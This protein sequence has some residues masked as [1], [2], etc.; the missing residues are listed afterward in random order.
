MSSV[1][2]TRPDPDALLQ[3]LKREEE[4]AKKGK[5]TIF[6]GMCA[7][8]G[9]TYDMLKTGQDLR[10]KGHDVII[11]YV[12]THHRQETEEL[13]T[14]LTILPRR[15]I[16]YNGIRLEEMDLDAIL[17][18]KPSLVLVDELAH[19]NIPGSRHAKRY[20]DVLE[21][22]D[23][24]ISVFTTLNVQHLESRAD[25][26]AQIAG[27][28]V[29][30]TVPD[31][32]FDTAHEVEL[33][34]L[35][36]D[37]LLK[38]LA[39]G[40]VYTAERSARA[41]QHFFRK[42]NLTALREMALR[43]T[44]ER[45]DRQL[46]EY[47][48]KE[49]IAG[50]WKSG[51]RLIVGI[52]ASPHSITLLRSVR[53]MAYA[54]NATWIA[55]YVERSAALSESASAQLARN[56]KLAQELGAEV[57][58]TSDEDVVQ[59]LLR[60]AHQQNATQIFIGKT[61]TFSLFHTPLLQRLIAGSGN[62][63][64]HIIG[65]E[66]TH[67]KER[68]FLS[69]NLTSRWTQYVLAAG[70]MI[71]AAAACYPF[72]GLLG[73]QSVSLILLLVMALLPLWFS[74][75]PVLLSAALSALL[76]DFLFIPPRF[77]FSV[78]LAQDALMLL[79]YFSIA[80][81]TGTLSARIRARERAVVQR[82]ERT[83][84][85]FALTGDLSTA[86]S[87]DDVARASV[88]NIAA[89]LNADTMVFLSEPDG[90]IFKAPHPASTLAAGPKDFSVASWVY[91]NEK[92]AGRFTETLPFAEATYVPLS[93]PRYSLGVL[94]VRRRDGQRMTL[95]QE[96]LLDNF[97]RQISSAL[98]RESLHELARRS[99]AIEESERL[100]KTLFNSVSHEM[101]TPLSA[102]LGASEGLLDPAAFGETTPRTELIGEIHA[103]ALRLN[104]LVENLL[105]MT[106][107]E[108]GLIKPKRDWCDVR[109]LIQSATKRMAAELGRHT[110][111]V[112]IQEDLPLF[113]LDFGM[114]EQALMNVLHNAVLYTP[115]GTPIR[116]TARASEREGTI[117]I[118]DQ[119]PGL[120]EEELE[121][122]FEKFH[123]LPG[124]RSG[125]TG[126]GLSIVRGFVESNGGTITAQNNSGGGAR[127]I[128]RLPLNRQP[129]EKAQA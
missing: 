128:I 125:G 56:I 63:D 69:V 118:A 62:L 121:R 30:E 2:I 44:A 75:G 81:V 112:S 93:G 101:R 41:V 100:Y 3:S 1:N 55:V 59:A 85:L 50:P 53:R 117:E 13:L 114:M 42:G 14:G 72:S 127:F 77:T 47:M 92:K 38:R 82:E 102:I 68:Q 105:D 64:V 19:T 61:R 23:N 83:A 91:W 25:A 116:I 29:R 4:V 27:A 46:R 26:V 111:Q 8:V 124:S 109:D 21:L 28:V 45:V 90:D 76:W 52:S 119:G 122:V 78:S 60:V 97:A 73:Y 96:V 58:S 123:R 54:L 115:E 95:D 87:Q 104:H 129:Q 89:S 22:L 79:T 15:S 103:A 43:L 57:V 66:Q 80:A 49:Q 36:P 9:K 88:K 99:V 39:E 40:K 7:G 94:G 70:V 16:D 126:L 17:A 65:E 48:S 24:G 67:R 110:V 71:G 106:R 32:I 5:L 20:Q 34:D 108:S 31:S 35:S 98:E 33:V 10:T 6:L 18:R 120:P 51:Q 37:D 74:L 107:L 84:A 113:T 11:G 86:R 12:E